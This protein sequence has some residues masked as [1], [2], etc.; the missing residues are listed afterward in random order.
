LSSWFI[1]MSGTQCIQYNGATQ[2]DNLEQ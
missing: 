1:K 2:Y